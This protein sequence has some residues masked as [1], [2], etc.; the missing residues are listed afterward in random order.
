MR[1][2]IGVYTRL[3]SWVLL[4]PLYRIHVLIPEI[5]TVAPVAAETSASLRSSS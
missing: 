1:I 5:L 2:D 3:I 4:D